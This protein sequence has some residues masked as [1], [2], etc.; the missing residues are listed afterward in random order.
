MS[1]IVTIAYTTE[2]TTD[3]RF[4]ESIIRKTFEEIA[5]ECESEIEVF[6]PV[7]I[8]FTK[9]QEFVKD[10]L[11]V[12]IHAYKIGMNVLCVH[13]DADAHNDKDVTE[14]KI[15]P[16]RE[17]LSELRVE[18]ACK[19]FVPI[20]PIHMSEAWMLADKELLKE[21]LGTN[22]T[23]IE[24]DIIRSPESISDPKTVIENAIRIVQEHLPKRRN[25]VTLGELY[26]PI[27]QK[28][29]IEKLEALS[30][31]KKFKSSVRNAFVDLNY[32]K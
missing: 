29:G 27:G 20:I 28:I 12:S 6:D 14:F 1:N 17:A 11:D 21:E 16:V 25:K 8:K 26:Q 30:S 3:Q 24:L 9:K 19:I 18:E 15:V 23:D 7:Y 2:G 31:F 22:K 4:L 5:Y 32:L 13:V 10:V